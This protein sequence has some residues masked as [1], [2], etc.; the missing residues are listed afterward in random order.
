MHLISHHIIFT[1]AVDAI[2]H[3]SVL[4]GA[5]ESSVSVDAYGQ[6]VVTSACSPRTFVDIWEK[7]TFTLFFIITHVYRR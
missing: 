1:I 4:T 7:P 3:V 6:T 5:S 2:S